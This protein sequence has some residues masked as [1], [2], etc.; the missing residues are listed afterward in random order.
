MIYLSKIKCA[1]RVI[2]KVNLV[3]IYNKNDVLITLEDLRNDSQD[4]INI[5]SM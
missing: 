1:G 4:N 5:V 2:S 3:Y